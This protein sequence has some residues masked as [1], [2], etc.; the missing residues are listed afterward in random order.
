[1][2]GVYQFIKNANEANAHT[3]GAK[4][5]L[6]G[7]VGFA[8]M[9]SAFALVRMVINTIGVPEDQRPTSIQQLR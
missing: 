4:H 8:I 2:W 3:D 1:M 7:F 5:L 9:M 6:W